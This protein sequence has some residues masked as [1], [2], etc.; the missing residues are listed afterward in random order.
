VSFSIPDK[1]NAGVVPGVTVETDIAVD[2][3]VDDS[4]SQL[5]LLFCQNHQHGRTVATLLTRQKSTYNA[6][7]PNRFYLIHPSLSNSI[8]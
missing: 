3:A 1:K 7:K 4:G 8:H 5:S 6:Q 2:K